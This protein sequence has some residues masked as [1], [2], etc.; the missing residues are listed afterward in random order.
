MPTHALRSVGVPTEAHKITHANGG[1]QGGPKTG[2]HFVVTGMVGRVEYQQAKA[3]AEAWINHDP[4]TS[5]SFRPLFELDYILHRRSLKSIYPDLSDQIFPTC[6]IEQFSIPYAPRT[7]ADHPDSLGMKVLR[8]ARA[9]RGESL[10]DVVQEP[11]K[12]GTVG[13]LLTPRQ[14]HQQA[15]AK[16]STTTSTTLSDDYTV[17]AA[18]ALKS[19]LAALPR[20]MTISLADASNGGEPWSVPPLVIEL[21]ADTC[22]KSVAHFLKYVTG[23]HGEGLSYIGS[24]VVRLV[25]CGWVE[26]GDIRDKN[27]VPVN[28]PVLE[29]ENFIHPHAPYTLAFNHGSEPHSNTTPFFI[30]LTSM[31]YFDRRYVAFGRIVEGFEA[32]RKLQGVEV[33][34]E[35]P[36]KEIWIADA[37]VWSGQEASEIMFK[38]F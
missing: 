34:G 32:L 24:R 8:A 9:G 10:E 3:A 4:T 33:A 12:P 26:F 20:V 22:P 14:L 23:E 28:E 18:S 15:Q 2:T 35:K 37:K 7:T 17:Q 6:I 5:A 13:K 36:V 1:K 21:F 27:G 30:T 11:V 38:H 29:D 31:P 19:N 16:L 25:E